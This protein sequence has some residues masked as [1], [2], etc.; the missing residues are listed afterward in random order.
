ML[1]KLSNMCQLIK[2][3]DKE[4]FL[5]VYTTTTPFYAL[6]DNLE[7]ETESEY[8]A[9]SKDG[10][11]YEVLNNNGGVVFAKKGTCRIKQPRIEKNGDEFAI[12]ALDY[13]E[14]D[15][16][17]F[18][19][20]DGVAYKEQDLSND[21]SLINDIDTLNVSEVT[22]FPD[23]DNISI[24]NAIQLTKEEYEYIYNKLGTVVNTGLAPVQSLTVDVSNTLTEEDVKSAIPKVDALYSDG[25]VQSFNVDWTDSLKNVDFSKEGTY[26]ITGQVIQKKYINKL[27]ELNNSVLS[28]DDPDN[29]NLYIMQDRQPIIINAVHIIRLQE[30]MNMMKIRQVIHADM[31]DLREF[32]GHLTVRLFL[33]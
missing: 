18:I 11:N 14:R 25:S 3:E 31:Q 21:K 1:A 16:H 5:A 6:T 17:I 30:K 4:Y 12:Y 29:A 2:A 7:Q 26:T 32:I 28:E 23:D 10:K 27:K 15:V 9:L 22:G 33:R 13:N 19:S 8:F 24:G 20:S